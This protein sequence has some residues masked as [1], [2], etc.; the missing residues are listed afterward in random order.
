MH[1]VVAR[2]YLSYTLAELDAALSDDK[3]HEPLSRLWACAVL[4]AAAELSEFPRFLDP[5]SELCFAARLLK[6]GGTPASRQQ[7]LQSLLDADANPSAHT[8]LVRRQIRQ[9]TIDEADQ[10]PDRER[11][12]LIAIEHT[13]M[14]CDPD[15]TDRT[16]GNAA[17]VVRF[18]EGAVLRLAV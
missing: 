17:V 12:S 11:R 6:N 7:L 5:G 14:L 3:P 13:E 15:M 4:R 1:S 18:P 8:V 10:L 9:L 16:F 2:D